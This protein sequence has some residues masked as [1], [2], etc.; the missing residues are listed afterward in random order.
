MRAKVYIETTIPSYLAAR[1]SRDLLTAAR[2]QITRDWWEGCRLRFDLFIS[3]PVIDESAAGDAVLSGRRLELLKGIPVLPL[4]DQTVL[5]AD[6]L[7]AEDHSSEGCRGRLPHCNS[8]GLCMRLPVDVELHAHCE[9]AN[10]A[11]N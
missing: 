9:R 11:Q 4:T 5:L 10:S 7:I 2:Q 1:P 3:Q 8:Y 6:V